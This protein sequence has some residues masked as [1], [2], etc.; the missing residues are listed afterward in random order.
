MLSAMVPVFTTGGST[1]PLPL[2]CNNFFPTKFFARKIILTDNKKIEQYGKTTHSE[3]LTEA[4]FA[5]V[6]EGI[7]KLWVPDES[8]LD[9][10]R[11]YGRAFAQ[12]L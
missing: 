6:N 4:G 10:C 11:E 8:N 3:I 2:I 9:D 5:L 1:L 12:A 7:A